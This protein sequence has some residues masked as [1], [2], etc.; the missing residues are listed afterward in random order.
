MPTALRVLRLIPAAL[1]RFGERVHQVPAGRWDASTPCSDWSVR[2][3]VNHVT[4]E[5]LWAPHLLRGETL[6]QVGDRYDGDV[7]GT[8]PPAS[9]D[10][11]AGAALEAWRTLAREGL[12]VHTSVGLMPVEEYA[13]QMHLDLVVHGWDLARGAGLDA[14]IPIEAAEH[15]LA[16]V[17]PR[18]EEYSGYGIFAPP[19][20]VDSDDPA[21]R[22]LGLLGRNPG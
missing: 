18:V 19:V 21:D 5:Q 1:E 11:A 13:E 7:L 22:L 14:G 6:E 10:T 15:V 12:E 4:S 16:F 9:W 2:D 8:D 3:L 20:A 17:E